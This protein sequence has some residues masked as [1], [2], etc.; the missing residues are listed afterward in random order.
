[1]S[2]KIFITNRINTGNGQIPDSVS[3]TNTSG[4][5]LAA[6]TIRKWCY[7]TNLGSRDVFIAIGQTALINKGI[8]LGKQGGS[9]DLD[10][11]IMSEETINGITL[12]GSS[13]VIFQ[14]GN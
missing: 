7:L 11:D 1:M 4:E 3:I 2:D 9:L 14:E 13:T 5:I 6:N 12:S 10:S 8:L